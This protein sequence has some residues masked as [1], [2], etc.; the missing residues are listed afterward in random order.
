MAVTL[1]YRFAMR[2][3]TA[4]GW[5]TLNEVLL[6]SEWGHESD[7]NRLKIGD[8]VTA[9]VDLPYYGLDDTGVTAGDYGIAAPSLVGFSVNE[10]GQLTQAKSVALEVGSGLS[11]DIDP[12]TGAVTISLTVPPTFDKRST[13]GGDIR[14]TPSG[15]I[16]VI[17]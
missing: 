10:Y 16:R 3:R 14:V 13:Q 1:N 11:L 17:R 9:W 2:R 12:I 4:A 15:D 6:Q 8:G 5:T 7:T